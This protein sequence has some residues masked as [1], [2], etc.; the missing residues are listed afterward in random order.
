[1]AYPN[2]YYG[3]S[4]MAYGLSG[5]VSGFAGGLAKR[6]EA[7]DQRAFQAALMNKRMQMQ[8]AIAQ[9]R[10]NAERAKQSG[11]KANSDDRMKKNKVMEMYSGA[12]KDFDS[13]ARQKRDVI[14][15]NPQLTDEQ[16]SDMY[17]TE[18]PEYAKI[19]QDYGPVVQDI[20]KEYSA[21]VKKTQ[22]GPITPS[23][24]PA[25]PNGP[26][27]GNWAQPSY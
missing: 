13:F 20:M 3:P 23:G 1:M 24:Q 22:P 25:A 21:G 12:S 18:K 15:G 2:D 4:P 9:M 6:R 7:N 17:L 14:S 19:L 27:A 16:I 26:D 8:M 10:A 5:L 11:S